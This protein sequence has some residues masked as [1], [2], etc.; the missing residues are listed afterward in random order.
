M[1]WRGSKVDAPEVLYWRTVK[2][3]EVHF[4]IEWKGKLLPIEVK[5]ILEHFING[6][7]RLDQ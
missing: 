2:G 3:E 4:V 7:W 6:T 1:A 5:A